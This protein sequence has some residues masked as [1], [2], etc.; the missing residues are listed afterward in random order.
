MRRLEKET[1]WGN[2]MEQGRVNEA[3]VRAGVAGK[4]VKEHRRK[5]KNQE[6]TV[7]FITE[8][9]YKLGEFRLE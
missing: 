5:T 2:H 3:D 7:L 8:T 6:N 4:A 9:E 1:G